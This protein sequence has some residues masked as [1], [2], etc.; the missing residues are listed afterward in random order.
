MNLG[1]KKC[2]ANLRIAPSGSKSS[3]DAHK[4]R[5]SDRPL[6]PGK[7]KIMKNIR[8]IWKGSPCP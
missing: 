6:L 7:E 3:R 5:K 1:S 8:E 2:Q 4:R